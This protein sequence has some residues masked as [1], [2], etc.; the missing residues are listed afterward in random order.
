VLF[1]FLIFVVSLRVYLSACSLLYVCSVQA[2]AS[3]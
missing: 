1:S 2:L 3:M